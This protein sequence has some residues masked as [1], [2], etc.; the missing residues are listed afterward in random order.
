MAAQVS[1]RAH[2][3][4]SNFRVGAALVDDNGATHTGC[5]VENSAYPEGTCAEAGAIGAMVAA[6][7]CSIRTIAIWGADV[8]PGTVCAPCGGCRQK[9]SEFAGDDTRIVLG[10]PGAQPRVFSI[11]ELLPLR[12]VLSPRGRR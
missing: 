6:G 11:D 2:A 7:G 4:Y 8:E 1:H 9:I 5:N 3:P 12:F 10:G